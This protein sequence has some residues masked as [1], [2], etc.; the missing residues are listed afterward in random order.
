MG[1]EVY[2]V[3]PDGCS[4]RSVSDHV[5]QLTAAGYPCH[6][7]ADEWG[8]CAVFDGLESTL[9]FTVEDGAAV[10]VTIENGGHE[11]PARI[12]RRG[13]ASVR[14]GGLGD[15]TG[16]LPRWLVGLPHRAPG[17]DETPRAPP[18]PSPTGR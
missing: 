5:Q 18:G 13:R 14:R 1:K 7:D 16:Y 17:P 15:G 6:E 9:N 8:H 12:V 10:F 2:F 3:A 11:R 4:R